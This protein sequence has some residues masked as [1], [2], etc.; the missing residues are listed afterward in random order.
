MCVFIS[1]SQEISIIEKHFKATFP[2][3][4]KI[5][6]IYF[7]SAFSFPEIPV[8]CQDSP[9]EIKLFKWGLI[10]YSVK[11]ETSANIIKTKTVNAK[12]ET[13]K[14]KPSFSHAVNNQRCI[15]IVNGFFEFYEFNKQKYLYYIFLLLS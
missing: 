2:Q 8:I 10:P 4:N 9:N 13:I 6:P 3:P 15:V 11:D 7:D 5:N 14:E 1:V 12:I